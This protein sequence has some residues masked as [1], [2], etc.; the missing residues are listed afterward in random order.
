[1]PAET[2]IL[3]FQPTHLDQARILIKS[4]CVQAVPGVA[5]SQRSV[6]VILDRYLTGYPSF[7]AFVRN[8]HEPRDDLCGLSVRGWTIVAR[9]VP[10]EESMLVSFFNG[11]ENSTLSN[12]NVDLVLSCT[13][14]SLA[15][16][17]PNSDSKRIKKKNGRC[18][19]TIITFS[20][21]DMPTPNKLPTQIAAASFEA[22]A[23]VERSGREFYLAL[24]AV[25]F[26]DCV[27]NLGSEREAKGPGG[28]GGVEEKGR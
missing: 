3:D 1:F 21:K 6:L 20:A 22:H 14:R 18:E 24:C 11:V 5:G 13:Y 7:Y 19:K 25:V 16:Y 27:Y 23:T 8:I 10:L 4:A 28:R 26:K 9:V 17:L 2:I 12:S 15:H